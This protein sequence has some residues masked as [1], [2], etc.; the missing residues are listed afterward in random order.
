MR[1]Y[2]FQGRFGSYVMDE[3]HLLAAVRYVELNPVRA[4]L[5]ER[6]DDYEHSSA[7]FHLDGRRKDALVEDR[8]LSGLVEDW[9]A[10]LDDGVEEFIARRVERGLSTGRPVGSEEFV[11]RLE[12][13]TGR[14]LRRRRP[15]PSKGWKRR[16]R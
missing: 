14:Q 2:L 12:K 1:G 8:S 4:R 16:R 9:Q 15:G 3:E 7:R 5:V 13:L 11:R 10:F 6:A